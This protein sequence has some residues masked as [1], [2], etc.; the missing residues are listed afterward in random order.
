MQPFGTVTGA[1]PGDGAVL[2]SP[3]LGPMLPGQPG[4]I[5]G[6]FGM[7]PGAV[8]TQPGAAGAAAAGD[9][10]GLGGMKTDMQ[11]MLD[12]TKQ[13]QTAIAS[14][15]GTRRITLDL[16]VNDPLGVM[17]LIKSIMGGTSLEAIVQE[18]GGAV[19]GTNGRNVNGR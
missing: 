18:N 12:M 13:I 19:P 10:T 7:L 9:P 2:G 6:A 1:M 8:P 16:G 5:P 4:G 3:L 11:A 14:I 15:G 17:P